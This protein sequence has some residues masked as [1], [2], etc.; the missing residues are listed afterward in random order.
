MAD[1]WRTARRQSGNNL[2]PGLHYGAGGTRAD[3]NSILASTYAPLPRG[4][5][6][7]AFIDVCTICAW[8]FLGLVGAAILGGP[9]IVL[10]WM[11][12]FG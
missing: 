5:L 4:E 8:V 6:A 11:L 9:V 3:L 1:H 12:F 7:Q 10:G 2:P